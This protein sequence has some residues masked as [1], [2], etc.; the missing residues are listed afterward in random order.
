MQDLG[1][2]SPPRRKRPS[3][4]E[5]R[6]AAHGAQWHA[7]LDNPLS[8]MPQPARHLVEAAKR[9]IARDGLASLSL[10][11]VAREAGE[12]KATTAYYFGNK[13]GLI[14]TVHESASHEEYVDSREQVQHVSEE[15]RLDWIIDEMTRIS[16]DTDDLRIAFELTPHAIRNRDLGDRLREL[17][18]WY[19]E[20][21]REWLRPWIDSM[22]PEIAQGLLELMAAVLDGMGIQ[23]L[24]KGEDFEPERAYRVFKSMLE[25][26]LPQFAGLPGAPNGQGDND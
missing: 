4:A 7:D 2:D 11:N 19:A 25:I 9:I 6:H 26:C 22:E 8:G 12:N 21:K 15:A 23:S 3:P 1:D 10:N 24:V 16:S 13:E 5:L 14:A 20:V 18:A 17:Y